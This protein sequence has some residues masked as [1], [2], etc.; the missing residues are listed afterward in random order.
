MENTYLYIHSHPSDTPDIEATQSQW[1]PDVNLK[2]YAKETTNNAIGLASILEKRL[3]VRGAQSCIK[4]SPGFNK[5]VCRLTRSPRGATATMHDVKL[6]NIDMYLCASGNSG[7]T[8]VPQNRF[9]CNSCW[10]V[11]VCG[12]KGDQP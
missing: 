11:L 6:V 12:D 9:L 5:V 3:G 7:L 4:T 8:R 10:C 1:N 2:I